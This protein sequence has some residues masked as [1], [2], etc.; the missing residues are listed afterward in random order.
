M[1][2]N[3]IINTDFVLVAQVL[4]RA[5]AW[6]ETLG[7]RFLDQQ[8]ANHFKK[9]ISAKYPDVNL[10]NHKLTLR[11]LKEAAKAKEILSANQ[12]T[13]AVVRLRTIWQLSL[14]I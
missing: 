9:V 4:V 10:D 8:I 1:C 6:D 13:Q 14:T 3:F 7:G 5:T 2:F 12:Q 11:L